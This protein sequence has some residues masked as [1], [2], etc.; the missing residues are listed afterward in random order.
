MKIRV[1]IDPDDTHEAT[2][3]ERERSTGRDINVHTA[4]P[5]EMYEFDL[6]GDTF[7]FV[8]QGA[9]VRDGDDGGGGGGAAV[10]VGTGRKLGLGDFIRDDDEDD[11][12]I[13]QDTLTGSESE[14]GAAFTAADAAASPGA[15]SQSGSEPPPKP[16]A[17]DASDAEI[18][19]IMAALESEPSVE[20]TK[21]GAIQ[22]TT[23]NKALE[24][25]NYKPISAAKRDELAA[26]ADA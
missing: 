26:A 19:V 14:S 1:G 4:Q 15:D 11:D 17:T 12:L 7:V 18:R 9:R 20:R 23:I 13:G 8:Q 25:R 16:D 3:I 6:N 10:N 2:L 22:V 5:G 24:A 21:D